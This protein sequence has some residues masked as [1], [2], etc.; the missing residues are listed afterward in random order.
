MNVA[1][2]E[3]DVVKR[4]AKKLQGF[5]LKAYDEDHEGAIVRGEGGNKLSKDWD[6]S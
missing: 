4:V 2:T 5:R 3:Y 6:I 1:C